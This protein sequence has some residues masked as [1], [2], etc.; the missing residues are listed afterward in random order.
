K[1]NGFAYFFQIFSSGCALP[2]SNI[3]FDYKAMCAF[4][5][6]SFCKDFKPAQSACLSIG[7]LES[8]K[9]QI[10]GADNPLLRQWTCLAV[11]ELCKGHAKAVSHASRIGLVTDICTLIS[12]PVPEV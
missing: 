3:G 5:L 11:A 8:A 4:I 10:A 12:D 6:A 1:D 7:F 9:I 2:P